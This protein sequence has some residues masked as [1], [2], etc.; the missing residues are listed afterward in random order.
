[1]T[2]LSQLVVAQNLTPRHSTAFH[3]LEKCA[4]HNFQKHKNTNKKNNEQKDGESKAG[5]LDQEA[6]A[7]LLDA[8]DGE[9]GTRAA[10]LAQDYV[11][12]AAPQ[13]QGGSFRGSLS[14]T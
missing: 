3:L 11:A 10:G 8:G 4:P 14:L 12:H 9:S 13:T 7:V 1:M 6:K 2:P 5:R